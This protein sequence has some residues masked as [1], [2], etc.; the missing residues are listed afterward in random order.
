VASGLVRAGALL[1]ATGETWDSKS[2]RR[3]AI[4]LTA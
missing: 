4:G 3:S 1:L 2:D